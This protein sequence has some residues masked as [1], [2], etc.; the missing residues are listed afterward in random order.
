MKIYLAEKTSG[1]FLS[2][3]GGF[4]SGMRFISR[5]VLCWMCNINSLVMCWLC[6]LCS[7]ITCWLCSLLCRLSPLLGLLLLYPWER[8]IQKQYLGFGEILI[9][10]GWKLINKKFE[11]AYHTRAWPLVWPALNACCDMIDDLKKRKILRRFKVCERVS[12]ISFD[13]LNWFDTRYIYSNIIWISLNFCGQK[14]VCVWIYCCRSW[15]NCG[16]AICFVL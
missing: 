15:E 7:L 8:Y 1:L 16:L 3:L 9:Q 14:L 4:S 13:C 12:S 10:C 11:V 5:L 6:H 2:M